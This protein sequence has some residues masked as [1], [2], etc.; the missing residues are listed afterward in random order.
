MEAPTVEIHPLPAKVSFFHRSRNRGGRR[1]L[2]LPFS[3]ARF[4]G[5]KSAWLPIGL[6]SAKKGT[7]EID[8]A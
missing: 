3:S 6:C 8:G 7:A 2:S 1:S 5:M 4:R